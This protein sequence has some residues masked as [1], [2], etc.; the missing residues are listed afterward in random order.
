MTFH[1][2]HSRNTHRAAHTPC[3]CGAP[4][5]NPKQ[6]RCKSCHARYMREYRK[7]HPDRLLALRYENERL[8]QELE[9]RK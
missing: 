6:G 4:R 5:E 1:A 7:R 9:A 8:K 2:K 3:P